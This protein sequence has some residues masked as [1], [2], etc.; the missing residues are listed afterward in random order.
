MEHNNT[1]ITD[2]SFLN[3]YKFFKNIHIANTP[4][5]K[6]VKLM[7]EDRQYEPVNW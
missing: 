4:G 5:Q 1:I 7:A 6:V 2:P 3:N